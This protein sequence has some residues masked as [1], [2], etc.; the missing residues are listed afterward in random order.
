MATY[1]NPYGG[2]G[3]PIRTRNQVIGQGLMRMAQGFAKDKIAQQDREKRD[4][5]EA[6]ALLKERSTKARANFRARH[7]C[8]NPGPKH[9]ARYWAC[10]TW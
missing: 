3:R 1:E 4:V 7:N 5:E 6:D 9:K 8:D 2:K 10:R